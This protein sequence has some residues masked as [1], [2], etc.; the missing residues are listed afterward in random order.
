MLGFCVL[1]K[2][3]YLSSCF[4]QRISEPGL[5]VSQI[6]K[7]GLSCGWRYFTPGDSIRATRDSIHATVQ[8]VALPPRVSSLTLGAQLNKKT[9]QNTK[10]LEP[11]GLHTDPIRILSLIIGCQHEAATFSH[12]PDFASAQLSPSWEGQVPPPS[13]FP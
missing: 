6:P 11:D 1:F 13:S 5:S 8:D 10:V 7:Q 3:Q 12:T 9:R 4:L 2:I